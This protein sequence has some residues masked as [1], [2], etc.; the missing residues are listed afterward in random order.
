MSISIYFHL[1]AGAPQARGVSCKGENN[2]ITQMIVAFSRGAVV[3]AAV[4]SGSK[5]LYSLG[6]FHLCKS[7]SHGANGVGLPEPIRPVTV[8]LVQLSCF[9]S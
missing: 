4:N 6:V 3:E 2:V 9:S 8:T 7:D 5:Q 1:F